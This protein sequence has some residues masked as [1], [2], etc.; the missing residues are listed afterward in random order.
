MP[1]IVNFAF[2]TTILFFEHRLVATAWERFF[3]VFCQF[4]SPLVNGRI[5][6]AQRTSDLRD[7]LATG[8]SPVGQLPL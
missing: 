1:I 2:E 4:P 3:A 5:G 6:D 7:G 8:L